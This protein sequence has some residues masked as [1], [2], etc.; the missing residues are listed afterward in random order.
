VQAVLRKGAP[1]HGDKLR[2]G[3]GELSR[4]R[5]MIAR[6]LVSQRP[7]DDHE[8]GRR[9]SRNDLAGRGEAEQQATTAC[10]Q[11]LGNQDRERRADD[12]A[13]DA[14]G[15][16]GKA[17]GI[18][19]GVIAGPGLERLGSSRSLEAT[20]NIA[21]GVE[22][23]HRR[24]IGSVELLLPARLPQ[25]GVREE[26]RWRFGAFVGKDRGHGSPNSRL[27]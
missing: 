2:V 5:I 12:T 16:S 1:G 25:Q 15:L 10:E 21:V 13:D 22:N 7:L 17:E 18:E 8:I 20:E 14:C 23:A 27:A 26:D 6:S 9:A 24:N 4:R 3:I 19:L 11:L